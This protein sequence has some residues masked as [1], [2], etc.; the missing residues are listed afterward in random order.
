MK[1]ITHLLTLL[2][3]LLAGQAS[4]Q[5]DVRLDPVRRDFLLG[6]NIALKVT[7]V[8]H[9]DQTIKLTNI[10]GR[11][12]LNFNIS[13]REDGHSLTPKATPRYPDLTI[14][15]GSTRSYQVDIKPFYNF[16]RAGTYKAIATVR[17][18]DMRTTY[19]SNRATFTLASGGSIKTFKT[20]ARGQ[21]LEM[22][23]KILN[24]GGKDSL[25]GQVIN[26]DSKVPLGACYLAQFLNFMEPRIVLDTAQNLH[27]LCQS[28][29]EYFTYSIMNT[30]G[31]RSQYKL[32]RR[33]GGPVDL[34]STGKGIRTIGLVPYVKSKKGDDQYH[35]A[36]DRPSR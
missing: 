35:S 34:I 14:S 24:V 13:S 8:N 11:S 3:I 10:P 23:V 17:M 20:Q 21:R 19:S 32:F 1:H 27:V 5:I 9:T 30:K 2:I 36:S 16:N 33:S 18:P 7:L 4:A 29:P 31:G 6:E 28:T 26:A 22:S 12:W 15:P 25:F